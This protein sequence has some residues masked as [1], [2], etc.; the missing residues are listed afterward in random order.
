MGNTAM[1]TDKP[2]STFD[3]ALNV[4]IV[5]FSVAFIALTSVMVVNDLQPKIGEPF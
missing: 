4:G 3:T 2:P 1:T 5:L